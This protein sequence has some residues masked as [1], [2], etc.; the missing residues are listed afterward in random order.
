MDKEN[1]PISDAI[2][3][4]PPIMPGAAGKVHQ[5]PDAEYAVAEGHFSAIDIVGT[6]PDYVAVV[7]SVAAPVGRGHRC[8]DR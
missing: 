6:I 2:G 5:D 3:P 1:I 8:R 7:V 4:G